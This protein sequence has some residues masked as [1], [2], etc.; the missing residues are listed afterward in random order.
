MPLTLTRHKPDTWGYYIDHLAQKLDTACKKGG[1]LNHYI[2]K[3]A[4]LVNR[5]GMKLK[6]SWERLQFD[7]AI[8]E[9]TIKNHNKIIAD[10]ELALRNK[11]KYES[12]DAYAA[13][14]DPLVQQGF[15]LKKQTEQKFNGIYAGN[16]T[17]RI[18]IHVPDPAFSPAGYS[19]FTNLAESLDF[20]GVPTSVLGWNDRTEEV[21]NKFN[22]TVLMS[23]DHAS[24]LGRIDWISIKKYRETNRLKIG[25]T[26]SLAEYDNTPL[27]SRLNWAKK[28]GI[29]FFYSFR[30]AEYVSNRVEYQP[31]FDEGYNILHLPFGANILHY[32]PVAGF[33][34]D[35]DYVLIATKK[36]EHT[37]FMK[38]VVKRNYG[39]I[40]GPGWKHAPH[41]KFNRD[42][43]K[44][45]YARAKIG[46][47]VHLPEQIDWACEVN[48]RTYQ[49]AAC[50][51]PQLI[52]HPKLLD[53]LFSKDALFIADT[54]KEYADYFEMII[55]DP[56]GC[57]ARALIAQKEVFD[58][59]T[60]FHRADLLM[61]QLAVQHYCV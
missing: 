49:L 29:N 56:K 43:D 10:A 18:L 1:E 52:D 45:I 27:G 24:Y 15:S 8:H 21:I 33:N 31:F 23:S 5:R 55:N 59:H 36:R 54:P 28:H 44:Y 25:L 60:T 12:N 7:H 9:S 3:V 30:D 11:E 37:I 22:P 20:M 42:K 51:V 50:G 17:E 39:F 6:R 14:H 19:L 41:F 35:I 57:E 13:S 26:A 58:K 4:A 32:Y 16:T 46:L 53:K 47:N 34:R 40:D 38:D 2:K 48:E 61:Q